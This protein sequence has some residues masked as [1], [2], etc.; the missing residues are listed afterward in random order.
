VSGSG[1][2]VGGVSRQALT[3]FIFVV[4]VFVL[5]AIRSEAQA[6][7]I[8]SV[9]HRIAEQVY[10]QCQASAA[11]AM[12]LTVVLN[13]IIVSTGTRKDLTAEQRARFQT[14]YANAKPR[15]VDCGEAP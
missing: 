15:V 11:N 8:E 6:R 12:T 14:I 2:Q 9:N 10:A 4:A 7:N 3:V 5:L 1:K 13:Q